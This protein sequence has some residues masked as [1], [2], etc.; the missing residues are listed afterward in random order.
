MKITGLFLS[1]MLLMLLFACGDST[2]N[3]ET[4]TISVNI[5]D[6]PFPVDWLDSAIVYIDKIEI[7]Q[8]NEADSG[9]PFIVLSEDTYR[10]NLL[11]LRNGEIE[12]LLDFEIPVGSYDLVRLHVES[13]LV[14]LK[15]GSEYDLKVPSGGQ[16]GIKVFIAPDLRIEGGLTS[17]LLLDFDLGK[18][19]VM[20]G[21]PRTPEEV[22][23]V[24]FKPVIRVANESVSGRISGTV[25]DTSGTVIPDAQV[26]LTADSLITTT[27]TDIS[28]SYQIIGVN[29][30]FYGISSSKLGYDTVNVENVEVVAGNM[31]NQDFILTPTSE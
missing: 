18:S 7:R 10:V 22:T 29:A 20:K 25:S 1:L 19:F 12:N 28:G 4:G 14:K 6:A 26:W 3:S 27:F 30:G 5:T 24:K 17:E 8:K 16:S 23:G 31:T 21:N 9:K 11:E 15:N 13:A 2:S